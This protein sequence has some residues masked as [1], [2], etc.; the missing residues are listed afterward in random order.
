MVRAP[1][2]ALREATRLLRDGKPVDAVRELRP[3]ADKLPVA[4]TA[5]VIAG[6]A[7]ALGL[8]TLAERADAVA[9]APDSAQALYDFGYECVDDGGLA[10]AAVPALTAAL[11]L[12]PGHADI[13]FELVVALEREH[14]YTEAV[15]VLER[16]GAPA[17]TWP[18]GYLLSA[19]ALLAGD[20]ERAVRYRRAL[21]TPDDPDWADLDRWL[22][23]A[24]QRLAPFPG[25]G[26]GQR[27]LRGWH[28][29]LNGGVLATLSTYGYDE[30]MNGRFAFLQLSPASLRH[31]LDRVR[32]ALAATDR[33]PAAVALLPDRSSTILG[34]TAA[35]VLDLPA[36][37]YR[38][39]A[40]DTAVFAF[41]L[42]RVDDDSVAALAERAPG[43]LLVE[44]ATRWTDP[45]PVAADLTVLL[46]QS[47]VPPWAERLIADRDGARRAPADDR[48]VDV[49][50]AELAAAEPEA[51]TGDGGPPDGDD[52]LAGFVSGLG[53]AWPVRS[54]VRHRVRSPG[55]VR[56][57]YFR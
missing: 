17:D 27:D 29:V 10:F 12:L 49:I 3:V 54:P 11:R 28:F 57:S 21:P 39:G 18:A 40:A 24:V 1:S 16:N 55:P 4:D 30:G 47:V 34:L 13:L 7:G 35:R 51:D 42:T 31:G 19:N 37:P 22:T 43:E 6:A 46:G 20:V 26:P 5:R 15:D 50:A 38:P 45:P 23:G 56:S 44:Y 33:R 25:T 53:A 48:P 14:R 9:V 52:V 36:H 32:L 8:T 41:D 2:H